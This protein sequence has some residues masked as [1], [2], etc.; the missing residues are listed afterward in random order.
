MKTPPPIFKKNQDLIT[1]EAAAWI[2]WAI[3]VS[4]L[5]FDKLSAGS[6]AAQHRILPRH[7]PI[8]ATIADSASLKLPLSV[9]VNPFV[10]SIGII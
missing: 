6:S 5:R 3:S 9:A 4:C 1:I 10:A 8:E 2:Q 7:A